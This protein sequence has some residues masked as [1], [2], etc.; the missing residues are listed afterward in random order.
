LT[1]AFKAARDLNVDM[2]NIFGDNFNMFVEIYKFKDLKG[3]R[4]WMLDICTRIRAY[5]S[6][7][8]YDSRK[9]V[10]KKAVEY[11]M[12]NYS[13]SDVTI[14]HVCSYLHISPTYFS[15]VFKK[16]TKLTFVNYLTQVR[17]EAAKE[18]LRSTD[19]KTFE[20]AYKVGYSEPNY[21]SYCFK[22]N[23][24]ISPSEYRKAAR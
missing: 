9:H 24:G 11:I 14:D 17:M 20:I 2:D 16:D 21:F 3:I 7:D 1:S 5:V 23:F 8:R 12:E 19:L 22:K 13:M 10:V 18:L 6:K 4:D 15:T